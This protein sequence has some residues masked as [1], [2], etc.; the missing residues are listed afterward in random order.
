[1]PDLLNEYI[2]KIKELFNKI[3][4]LSIFQ[5]S[6]S[7]KIVVIAFCALIAVLL[8]ISGVSVIKQ[9]S[10]DPKDETTS[11]TSGEVSLE[12]TFVQEDLKSNCLFILTDNDN[13]KIHCLVL[14]NLDS[15]ND[16]IRIS[17][18]D[19]ATKHV[20]SNLNGTMHEHLNNGGVNELVWAVSEKYSVEIDRYLMGDELGF[21]KL[22]SEFDNITVEIEE[23]INHSHNGVSYIIESGS[24]TF[25]ADMML[26]YF[27][28][29]SS[30]KGNKFD[31]AVEAMLLYANEIFCKRDKEA[32]ANEFKEEFENILGY[33]ETNISALDYS[34]FKNAIDS[35]SSGELGS[36]VTIVADPAAFDITNSEE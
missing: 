12:S 20:V 31:K 24:Q 23:Q 5:K 25:T 1:M 15:E 22:M 29:I 19:P 13:E 14:V 16:S 34:R 10:D 9:G 8:V 26:K 36:K 35:L 18:V 30:Y 17:F 27:L 6:P 2:D 3:A 4:S 11:D 33:F 28:Y 7:T 32:E 21:T